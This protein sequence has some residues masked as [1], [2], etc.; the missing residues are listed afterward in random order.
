[1]AQD[2]LI[3]RRQTEVELLNGAI[4]HYGRLLGIPTP[5]NEALTLMIQTI[6]KNYD[7]QYCKQ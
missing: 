6:Q 5:V 1:M 7:M 4:V 2:V 3:N